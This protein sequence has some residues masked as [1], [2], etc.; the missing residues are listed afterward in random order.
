MNAR[1]SHTGT[2][3]RAL[4][5]FIIEVP[6]EEIEDLHDRLAHARWPDEVSGAGW[7]YGAPLDHLRHLADF[8]AT[9]Y[10]WRV[11]EEQL[12]ALPQFVTTID[13]QN[14]H[15]LHVRSPEPNALPLLLLHGWPSSVVEFLRMIGPLTDPAAHGGDPADA[16]DVVVPSL[17]GFGFSGPTHEKGWDRT[18]MA[19]ALA[20]LM[21]RLG[22][23]RFGCHGGDV[24]AHIARELGVQSPSGFVGLHVLQIFAF[25]TG[26]KT[27]MAALTDDDKRRIA[28]MNQFNEKAGYLAIQSTRPQTLAY[29]LHDSPVGQLAWIVDFFSAFGNTVDS[30]DRDLLLTNVMIYWLTGTAGSSSRIYFEDQHSGALKKEEQNRAPTGVAVFPNDFHSIRRFAE[31]ANNIVHWEE[32]DRGG[33]FAAMEH[34]DLLVED[35]RKFFR[36]LR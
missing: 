8:W 11:H 2:V 4:Q 12:N 7:N 10:D 35:V 36:R 16:F 33:H 34:P 28:W 19:R 32:F 27:E 13:G 14:L 30:I 23:E 1:N 24:G 5:P 3:D 31:R 17:P 18:R 26:D 21:K 22:Y 15:F 6:E 29:G 25:P 9:Q 20:D